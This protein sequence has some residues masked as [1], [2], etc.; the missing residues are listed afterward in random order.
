MVIRWWPKPAHH[1]RFYPLLAH[2][3]TEPAP[4]AASQGACALV[5]PRLAAPTTSPPAATTGARRRGWAGRGFGYAIGRMQFVVAYV[6]P[7]AAFLTLYALLHRRAK[8]QGKAPAVQW[9]WLAAI[10]L[11]AGA[12]MVLDALW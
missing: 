10:L 4:A 9:G 8:R 12:V 3:T 5:R 7:L 1:V 11:C 2:A 6:L